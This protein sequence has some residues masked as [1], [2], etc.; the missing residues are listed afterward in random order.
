MYTIHFATQEK[1]TQHCKST[2][3]HQKL[4]TDNGKALYT[5]HLSSEAS[6]VAQW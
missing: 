1:L 6:Q 5:G 4:K 2:I 3:L